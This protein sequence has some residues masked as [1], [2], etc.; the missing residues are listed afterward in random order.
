MSKFTLRNTII[1]S[2]FLAAGLVLP[3]FFHTLGASGPIFLPM[4]IPVLICGLTLGWRYGA[5]CGLILPLLSSVTTGMPP[6]YPMAV[7]M[8]FELTAYGLISGLLYEKFK[9]YYPALIGAMLCGRVANGVVMATLMGLGGNTYGLSAFVSS[10]VVV[11][12]PGI[13]IQLIVVVPIAITLRKLIDMNTRR[14]H[15]A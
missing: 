13:V 3:M 4:H 11:A 15:T 5:L 8:T 1:T 7:V 9:K 10:A 14:N 12:L 6:L 2:L